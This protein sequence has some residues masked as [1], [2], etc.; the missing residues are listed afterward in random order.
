LNTTVLCVIG[1]E[2]FDVIYTA[3]PTI[4]DNNVYV[5]LLDGKI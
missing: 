4:D 1:V 2:K 3:Q 5:E